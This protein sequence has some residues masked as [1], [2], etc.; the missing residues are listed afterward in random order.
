MKTSDFDYYLPR[1]FIAQTPLEPRDSSRLLLLNRSS[2]SMEHHHFRDLTKFLN[3]DDVLVFN[4][5]R[6]LPARLFGV[7]DN[8]SAKIELLLLRRIEPNVWECM[9]KPGKK[10]RKG[11]IIKFSSPSST[12]VPEIEAEVLKEIENGN[13]IIQFSNESG[14]EKIGNMPLPPYIHTPLTQPERYQTVYARIKGSAA[15]PT[16]GLHF[17]PGLLN[18]LQQKGVQFVFVTLHIGLDT[19]QP[20]R[21]DNPLAHKIHSEFGEITEETADLLNK[22]KKNKKRIIAVGTSTTRIIEAASQS[23]NVIPM[24]ANISLFILPGYKF[25]ITDAMITNFH[26][27]KS[28]LI[29]LVSAFAGKEFIFSAYQEAME[30]GYRFYS[31]GDAMLII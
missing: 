6:V 16:A 17:T 25:R 15:A 5:S 19:F 20:V 30:T 22:A 1:E 10:I 31:F 24:K 23:E 11:T 2:H 14:L 7:L 27:P 26:L 12:G 21:T 28:T 8:S 4:D 13:R 18:K 3:K 29:M 9:A